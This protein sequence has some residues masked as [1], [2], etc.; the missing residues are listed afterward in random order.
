ME[1]FGEEIT[2][3]VNIYCLAHG[4]EGETGRKVETR[5]PKPK[6]EKN[7]PGATYLATLEAW[8]TGKSIDQIARMRNLAAS[9]IEGHFSKLIALGRM[10]VDAL[11][12]DEK[13]EELMQ[14]F[15]K[16]PGN[17]IQECRNDFQGKVSFAQARLARSF[18]LG[19]E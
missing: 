3:A 7:E 10:P 1:Q 18:A 6:K 11:L 8:E 19:K 15:K 9:T 14:Y 2:D 5:E 17:S 12:S 16:N 4:L 13:L